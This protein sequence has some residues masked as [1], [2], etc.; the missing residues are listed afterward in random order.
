M[1]IGKLVDWPKHA[2]WNPITTERSVTSSSSKKRRA[3]PTADA[4]VIAASDE[5]LPTPRAD[6]PK[7]AP[8]IK[9][10]ATDAP[11]A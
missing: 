10:N 8:R 5:V 11:E 6:K 2:E 7:P 9:K 4:D 3:T 1:A